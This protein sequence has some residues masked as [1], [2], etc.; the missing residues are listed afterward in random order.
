MTSPPRLILIEGPLGAGKSTTAEWLAST[1]RAAGHPTRHHHE[2]APDHPIRMKVTQRARAWGE[3]ELDVTPLDEADEEVF[4]APQWAALAD[5]AARG[6]ETLVLE[7][8]LI[9]LG[10]MY[11]LLL[12]ASGATLRAEAARQRAAIEVARPLLVYLDPRDRAAHRART[13]A[14][15]PE[16]WV[17][18]LGGFFAQHPFARGL[19]PVD[20]FHAVLDA[21]EP[22]ERELALA[23]PRRVVIA[24]PYVDWEATQRAIGA[25]VG[26][27]VAETL[28]IVHESGVLRLRAR[29]ASDEGAYARL[30]DDTSAARVGTPSASAWAVSHRVDGRLIGF[31]ERVDGAPAYVLA[32]GEASLEAELVAALKGAR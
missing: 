14:S 12:G 29:R 4:T 5:E 3:G 30:L 18:W 24:D 32:A 23:H 2:H 10:L 7:G 15:R 27:E 6:A 25:A 31:A 1:L 22:Y 9:Q 11:P 28:R 21:W 8:K 17:P 16:G 20:A 19:D 13:I 26:V